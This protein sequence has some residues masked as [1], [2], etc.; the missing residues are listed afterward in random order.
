VSGASADTSLIR[1]EWRHT[2]C[3]IHHHHHDTT[4]PPS[5]RRCDLK[6]F[7]LKLA[8]ILATK[9]DMLPQAYTDSLA[10]LLDK[11]GLLVMGSRCLL[12][13]LCCVPVLCCAVMCL[14]CAVPCCVLRHA[15]L[16]RAVLCC[17]LPGWPALL[18]SC[19]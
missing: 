7:Y 15:V 10:R 17:C 1:H 11:V 19:R 16:C 9:T 8:Q 18:W 2:D 3:K 12:L 13:L 4:G 14:W 6:G 5:L